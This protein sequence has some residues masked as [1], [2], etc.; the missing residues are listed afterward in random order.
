MTS[1]STSAFILPTMRAAPAGPRV[2]GFALD[3][4]EEPLLHVRRRDEEL[5]VEPLPRDSR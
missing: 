3:Q 2:L 1:G 5:A 4:L